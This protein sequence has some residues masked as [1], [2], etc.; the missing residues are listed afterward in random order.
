M[1][2]KLMAKVD[3]YIDRLL[4]KPELTN[5]EFFIVRDRLREITYAEEQQE[6]HN[7]WESIM[8]KMTMMTANVGLNGGVNNVQM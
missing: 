6:S 7:R 8:E 3:E 5:E 1:K 4:E 2:E